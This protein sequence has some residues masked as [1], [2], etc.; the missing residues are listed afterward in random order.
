MKN[1]IFSLL[2]TLVVLL[3]AFT[4]CEG[5]FGGNSDTTKFD[6]EM[7]AATGKWLLLGDED[8]YFEFNGS[9][10]AMTFSYCEDG[11]AR[12]SGSFRAIH[13]NDSDANTPLSFML[14]RTDK[15][16]EDWLSCYTEGFEE[17]FSQFSIMTEEE[18]LGVTDGTV[19]THIYRISELP[20][21]LGTYV[22]E[23]REYKAYEKDGFNDGTYR[24]PEGTYV[25]ES[26]ERLTVVP[27]M[28][29]SYMLFRYENGD[30]AI[31]GIF[32][33]AEDR[34][35]I[36]LYI[37]HDIYEKVK[38]ADKENY[39]TTFSLNYPPDFYL[40]G[41]FDTTS[42]DIVINGL[43]HHEYSPSEIEDSFWVFGT[44]TKQ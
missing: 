36:Y 26:G 6:D 43:Y 15:D 42:N 4:G 32:N 10:G 31:E 30:T 24:I 39:D 8:T 1:R 33:I 22:L 38:D 44:Y 19:Y 12:Y 7:T 27:L 5:L 18:D 17:Y 29:K 20:Y 2:L 28:S 16:N 13:K 21:K 11:E 9:K 34:K 37:E 14:T 23:G 25:S 41:D 35:T 40:R 3:L